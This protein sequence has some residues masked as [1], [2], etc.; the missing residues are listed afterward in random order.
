MKHLSLL[1]LDQFSAN[2]LSEARNIILGKSPLFGF[3]KGGVLTNKDETLT[4]RYN[5]DY[6]DMEREDYDKRM[7]KPFNLGSHSRETIAALVTIIANHTISE[8][9][10]PMEMTVLTVNDPGSL[11]AILSSSEPCFSTGNLMDRTGKDFDE[12]G[13]EDQERILEDYRSIEDSNLGALE[14]NLEK[15]N[16]LFN[17]QLLAE[18]KAAYI[19]QR[20][21]YHLDDDV[22][23]DF[24]D[25][26]APG[27][28]RDAPKSLLRSCLEIS[29]EIRMMN[30][31]IQQPD[32]HR[33]QANM[34]PQAVEFMDRSEG[35]SFLYYADGR[36]QSFTD[37]ENISYFMQKPW[38]ELAGNIQ[39]KVPNI[40]LDSLRE[41][42]KGQPVLQ[43]EKPAL[44]P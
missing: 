38:V 43:A 37:T 1:P 27:L 26:S 17:S 32:T 24:Y 23:D 40:V 41:V 25:Y 18:A 33:R 15:L 6:V 39:L 35:M 21:N 16:V 34:Y 11:H 9:L 2:A 12:F 19:K 4:S 8:E 22:D 5:Q 3:D 29:R 13:P 44:I 30:Q 10:P 20:E 36:P 42:L 14:Q 28:I 7:Y 31:R